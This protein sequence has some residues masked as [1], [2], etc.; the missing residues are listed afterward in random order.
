MA[1][2]NVVEV[3]KVSGSKQIAAALKNREQFPKGL[4]TPAQ[5][6]V[7]FLKAKGTE[8]TVAL[9]NNV[10]FRIRKHKADKKAAKVVDA[11][12]AVKVRTPRVKV[13]VPVVASP[14]QSEF[15]QMVA[16]KRLATEFG[17]LDNL[18]KLIEKVRLIAS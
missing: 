15:D 7:D 18:A 10:K 3:K 1:D 2:T 9:V 14:V 13:P 17:G 5:E 16:V 11:T 4:D 8:V 6:V 12:P